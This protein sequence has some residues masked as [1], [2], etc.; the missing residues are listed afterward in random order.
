MT[1]EEKKEY[2]KKYREKNKEKIKA[3]LEA[4]KDKRAEYQK[5]YVKANKDKTA[6]Y[7]KEYRKANKDKVAEYYKV[8]KD[9]LV[10]YQIEYAKERRKTDPLY[11]LKL[12]LRRS[13]HR[14]WKG[15]T[16]PATTE[17]LL[18]CSYIE[19]RDYIQ[20]QFVGNMDWEN[21]GKLWHVD[22]IIPLAVIE[23]V[24]QTELISS[25]CYYSNL[26]PLF[27]ED[28]L[29]KNDKLDYEYT[30]IYKTNLKHNSNK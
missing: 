19:F 2:D 17:K 4:N 23:D 25:L 21:Y 5:E 8:N 11:K 7:Q 18:G 1:K 22:H 27:A 24:S 13:S 28:N 3:Y 30:K 10:E 20:C 9:K 26:Q 14:A 12:N 15:T 29:S 16:K 6:E